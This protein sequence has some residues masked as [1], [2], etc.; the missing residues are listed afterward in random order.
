MFSIF[1]QADVAAFLTDGQGL[2]QEKSDKDRAS[3]YG[4]VGWN[5]KTFY[6]ALSLDFG[7]SR[8]FALLEELKS[9]YSAFVP[10]HKDGEGGVLD[11][12]TRPA[13]LCSIVQELAVSVKAFREK[14]QSSCYSSN[15]NSLNVILFRS[16]R[17]PPR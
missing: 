5:L 1:S 12:E 17:H 6:E 8:A 9:A 11:G 4:Y 16:C 7:D 13:R 15:R 2:L 10:C 3:A 14:R